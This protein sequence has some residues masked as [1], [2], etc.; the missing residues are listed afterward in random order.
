M[1]AARMAEAGEVPEVVFDALEEIKATKVFRVVKREVDA[2]LEE[3]PEEYEAVKHIVDNVVAML[4]RD[5]GI[6]RERLMEIPAVVQIIDYTMY[7]FHSV[8]LCRN[9]ISKSKF[10][11][12]VT[13]R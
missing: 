12:I 5:V 9:V 7:H 11:F 3:Y 2:V 4:K 1:T 10:A 6:V 13:V 8:C